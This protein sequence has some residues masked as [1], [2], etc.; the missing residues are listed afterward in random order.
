MIKKHSQNVIIKN[1][2]SILAAT[3]LVLGFGMYTVLT[4]PEAT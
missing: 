4:E 3:G 2:L 1:I